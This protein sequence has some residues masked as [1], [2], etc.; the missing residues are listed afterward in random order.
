MTRVLLIKTSSMG[1]I[2]H[3]LPVVADLRRALPDATID[4]VVEEAYVDLVRLTRGLGRVLPVALRRWRQA[5]HRRQALVERGAF[6][7][8]LRSERYDIVLDTQGLLKSA[9]VARRARLARH[10]ARVGFAF[11]LVREGPAR[12]FYDRA[13][14]VDPRLHAIERMR[15]AGRGRVRLFGREPTAALRT[16]RAA[17]PLPL[18]AGCRS[19][20]SRGAA[21]R[22]RPGRK[23]LA[24]RALGRGDRAAGAR[25]ARRGAAVGQRGGARSAEALARDAMRRLPASSV[26]PLV[27]PPLSLPEAAALLG[28]AG[29]SSASTRAC[30]TSPRRSTCRPSDCSARRRA[31]ATPRI[32]RRSRSTSAPSA[33]SAASPARRPSSKRSRPSACWRCRDERSRRRDVRALRPQRLCRAL[34][35]RD[36]ADRRLPAVALA[37]PAG[38]PARLAANAFSDATG[39]GRVGPCLWIHAVS[40]GETR[41]AAPLVERLRATIR[42][43]RSC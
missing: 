32:G 6:L 17:R 29:R 22:D 10:G 15:G 38:V 37:T 1:D 2:V 20:R 18:A 11:G 5:P 33:N 9:L 21:A 28:G 34:V 23:G 12:L 39:R 30:C 26:P 16:R 42:R 41:A 7:S 40:V 31:G 43:C 27:A 36:A 35:A 24:G 13:Y 8:Q 19:A 4:W 3:N 14:A 25:R